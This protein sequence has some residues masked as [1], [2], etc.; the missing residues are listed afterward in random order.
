MLSDCDQILNLLYELD[1]HIDMGRFDAAA[2]VFADATLS[3][4]GGDLTVR[5]RDEVAAFLRR[6]IRLHDDGTPKT[7]HL[8]VNPI[9][10]VDDTAGTASAQTFFTVFHA[11]DEV[12][13]QPVLGG[14]NF[15]TFRRT[16]RGWQLASRVVQVRLTG[17][18]APLVPETEGAR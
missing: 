8:T 4:H 14:A 6:S 10:D 5:G 16:E 11:S 7:V 2:D 13:L 9:V 1:E 15:D 3:V 18:I 17:N 12:P